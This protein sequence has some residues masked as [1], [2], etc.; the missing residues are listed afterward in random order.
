MVSLSR[1]IKIRLTL[2]DRFE[3]REQP[4]DAYRNRHERN[5]RGYHS[6]HRGAL[7]GGQIL[8]G[9]CC[10]LAGLYSIIHAFENV[11]RI[12]FSAAFLRA[13]LGYLGMLVGTG[14]A[15]LGLFTI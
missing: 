5:T 7:L 15:A 3:Q 2:P 1:E 12:G 9:A 13:N 14:V 4:T 8:F 10:F 11:D 6:R